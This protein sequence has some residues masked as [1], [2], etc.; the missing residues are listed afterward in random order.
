MALCGCVST[1]EQGNKIRSLSDATELFDGLGATKHIT[2]LDFTKGYW[3]VPV[4]PDSILKIA[5]VTKLGKYQ[6]RTMPFGLV[7]APSTFQHMV[8]SILASDSLFAAA[9]LD[10]V[11][12][13]S[14]SWTDH[15][16]HLRAVLMKLRKAGLMA[17]L[18]KCQF[19][20]NEC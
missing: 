7:G 4:S 20:M 12:I 19:F 2:M 14:R 16:Q 15:L 3:Q 9:Y 8:N 11:V 5:F 17:K 13:F 18:S 1:T 6:F 10:D